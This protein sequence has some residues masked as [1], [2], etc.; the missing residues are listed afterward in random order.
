MYHAIVKRVAAANFGR[1]ND[2]DYAAIL[3]TCAPT[4]EHRFGGRHALGGSRR[5]HDALA[6]WFDR[7]GRLMP[8]L[9]L[10]VEDT[11][12]TGWPHHTTVVIRWTATAT[13]PDGTA[14]ANHGVHV[15]TMRWGKAIAID[16]NEDSQAVAEALVVVAA[17]G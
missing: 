1:V 6:R 17:C 2:H 11:W 5:G 15:I 7:L 12:V 16:A 9:R 4:I 3:S 13:L 10:T 8:T 14:Y